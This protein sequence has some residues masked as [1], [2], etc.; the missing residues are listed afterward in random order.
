[1]C[2]SHFIVPSVS[3]LTDRCPCAAF[4]SSKLGSSKLNLLF[5]TSNSYVVAKSVGRTYLIRANETVK[6]GALNGRDFAVVNFTLGTPESVQMA[7]KWAVS[8]L[9]IKMVCL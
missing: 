2:S 6:R 1:M 7:G 5:A 9:I 4:S 8:K 3:R